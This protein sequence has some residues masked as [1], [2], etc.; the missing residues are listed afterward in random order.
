[1]TQRDADVKRSGKEPNSDTERQ[2]KKQTAEGGQ[3]KTEVNKNGIP[4]GSP[5]PGGVTE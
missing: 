2:E 3:Q 1:M 5:R 4:S